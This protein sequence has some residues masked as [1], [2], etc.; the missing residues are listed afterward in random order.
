MRFARVVTI[1]GVLL[2]GLTFPSAILADHCGGIATVEPSSGPAG[3][4]FVFRTNQGAPT[5]LYLYHNG[6]LVKTDTLAGDGFVSYRIRTDE[7]DVGRWRVRAAVQGQEECRGEAT[8]RVTGLP[9]T[10]IAPSGH[11]ASAWALAVVVGMLGFRLGWRR[12]RRRERAR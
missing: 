3:T 5:N 1:A 4:T 9:D 6:K 7:G 12:S 2:L 8:F 10:A 11:M